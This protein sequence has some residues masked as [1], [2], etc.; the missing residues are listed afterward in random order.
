MDRYIKFKE[1]KDSVF[2]ISTEDGERIKLLEQEIG[3]RMSKAEHDYLK[4]QTDS[5]VSR[6]D[7]NKILCFAK[8]NELD[9]AWV[10]QEKKKEKLKNYQEKL[11][12]EAQQVLEK[13]TREAGEDEDG[14]DYDPTFEIEENS[15]IEETLDV[16]QNKSKQIKRRNVVVKEENVNDPLPLHFSS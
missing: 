12:L 1:E 10:E 2:D 6:A 11:K 3:I 15:V 4:S 13:V 9:P 8:A 5:K 7:H 16:N 14:D